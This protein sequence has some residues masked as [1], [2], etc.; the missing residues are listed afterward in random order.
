MDCLRAPVDGHLHF[1]PSRWPMILAREKKGTVVPD[2]SECLTR[3]AKQDE[4]PVGE[5]TP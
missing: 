1:I 5:H 3:R 4:Q 2:G